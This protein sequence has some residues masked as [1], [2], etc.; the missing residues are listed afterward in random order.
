MDIGLIY[1][2]ISLV[3]D[4]VY[5]FTFSGKFSRDLIVGMISGIIS[6]ISDLK[7]NIYVE[8]KIGANRINIE[9]KYDIEHYFREYI[10]VSNP[11][12]YGSLD[13]Y[14]YQPKNNMYGLWIKSSIYK[15]EYT[16]Y[17]FETAEFL[18]GLITICDSFQIDFRDI[19]FD[20]VF[21]IK[22]NQRIKYNIESRTHF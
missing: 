8:L 2:S 21:K 9:N 14:Q 6:I 13:T 5:I 16:L 3:K 11:K 10:I 20:P 1:D 4:N 12:I 18:Q 7:D 15:S 17:Q 22:F 19:S